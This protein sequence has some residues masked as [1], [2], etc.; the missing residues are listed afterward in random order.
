MLYKSNLLAQ[1][2]GSLDGTTFSHNRFGK[3]TRN[4]SIP[5]DP[6]TTFQVD[7]RN[8]L[9]T[10]ASAWTGL[11]EEQRAAWD[12]YAANVT[13]LNPLGDAVNLTGQMHYVRSNVPRL[14]NMGP[15]NRINAAPI[16]YSLPSILAPTIVATEPDTLTVTAGVQ[17]P[18]LAAL[19]PL[20]VYASRPQNPSVNFFKGPYRFA[21]L[22]TGSA[23]ANLTLPF[24]A[25]ADQKLFWLLRRAT[26]D[27]RLST[28]VRG[29]GIVQT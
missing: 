27:G 5:T 16:E 12:V 23:A 17:D 14:V 13:V 22:V 1:A 3:Y 15:T 6:A 4:R 11:T 29:G 19:A 24:V 20:L 8:A 26:A 25:A 21:G 28:D 2:S 10:L 7:V 9:S 18:V